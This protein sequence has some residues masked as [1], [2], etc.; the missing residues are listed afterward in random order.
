LELSLLL[1]DEIGFEMDGELP[2]FR[3][4]SFGWS[5]IYEADFLIQE[6]RAK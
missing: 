1:T 3:Q 4:H 5:K 6:G 2:A